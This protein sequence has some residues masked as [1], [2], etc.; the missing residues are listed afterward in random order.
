MSHGTYAEQLE[1][2]RILVNNLESKID[3]V[4]Q[5]AADR[6]ELR[7]LTDEVQRLSAEIEVASGQLRILTD[8]R[9][10][11]AHAARQKRLLIAAH[12]QG[13]FGFDHPGLLSFGIEPRARKRRAKK[14]KPSGE[15]TPAG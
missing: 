10:K 7:K 8:R 12:L 2:W 11:A 1:S 6:A 4:P 5:A 9:R 13:H 3:N 14:A 15:G